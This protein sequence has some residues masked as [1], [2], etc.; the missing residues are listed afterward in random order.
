MPNKYSENYNLG[1]KAWRAIQ[2]DWDTLATAFGGG[3]LY[4]LTDFQA[5]WL[6]ANVEYL[7][8]QTRQV[9][10]PCTPEELATLADELELALM[11]CVDFQPYQLDYVYNNQI[12][13]KLTDLNN[14]WNGNPSDLNPN[15]P[16]DFF[17][18]DGSDF[19]NTALCQAL[20]IYVY[21]YSQNW[22]RTA[23]TV[24]GVVFVI[25]LLSSITLIGGIVATVLVGGLTFITQQALDA[26]QDE[27]ALDN[28]V[29]CMY[30]ALVG[31]AI[32]QATWETCLS[33]CGFMVGSN[34][35]IIR[36]IVA[37]DLDQFSN[38]LSFLEQLGLQFVLAEAGVDDCPCNVNPM[39]I[40]EF[41]FTVS[42]QGFVPSTVG[43]ST[44]AVY[45]AGQGWG[46]GS[47]ANQIV[48]MKQVPNNGDFEITSIELANTEAGVLNLQRYNMPNSF[49]NTITSEPV[50]AE[51]IKNINFSY[52]MMM[53]QYVGLNYTANDGNMGASVRVEKIIFEGNGINPF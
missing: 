51:S 4:C 20:K 13:Q 25:G 34:E 19:R 24:L 33:G 48:F 21:S 8:W 11:S 5:T 43:G 9:N 52:T 3:K 18:G 15:S 7:R 38:Y 44:R 32:S 2:Y 49:L 26:M 16:D 29:C 42:D 36:D 46:V 50:V 37:S 23:Q 22:V 14:A 53:N 1:K 47:V 30:D 41:D 12:Q 39:W 35:A 40:Q 6:Q 10:C 31:Q 17:N 45:N 28:V 27:E